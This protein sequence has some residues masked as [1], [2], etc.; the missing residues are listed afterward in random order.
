M[1]SDFFSLFLLLP[2]PQFRS[3][4]RMA[5][6]SIRIQISIHSNRRCLEFDRAV[7]YE[8]LKIRRFLFLRNSKEQYVKQRH[9]E[10][11]EKKWRLIIFRSVAT[12]RPKLAR[13]KI[14]EKNFTI[15]KIHVHH[16]SNQTRR[17]NLSKIR[18]IFAVILHYSSAIWRRI[19]DPRCKAPVTRESR[20]SIH[21]TYVLPPRARDPESRGLGESRRA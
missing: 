6:R 20:P 18:R 12:F 11:L 17:G 1:S 3:L 13:I 21:D 14:H 8:K 16:P 7:C 19:V 15:E 10:K 5:S 4:E 9:K 2:A